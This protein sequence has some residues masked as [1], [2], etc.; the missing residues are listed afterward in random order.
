MYDKMRLKLSSY[1]EEQLNS[2]G[3]RVCD[4]KVTFTK[5]GAAYKINSVTNK[6]TKEKSADPDQQPQKF[7]SQMIIKA[8]KGTKM[9]YCFR[10]V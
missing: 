9:T 1:T 7:K 8:P 4:T 5:Y 3:I 2:L 10:N 6:K